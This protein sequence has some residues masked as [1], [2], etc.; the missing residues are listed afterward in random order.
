MIPPPNDAKAG[1]RAWGSIQIRSRYSRRIIAELGM[2]H[3]TSHQPSQQSYAAA[4][5]YLARVP[6]LPATAARLPCPPVC[7][8]V[9]HEVRWS[10]ETRVS[11]NSS[12]GG[13]QQHLPARLAWRACPALPCLGC[14]GTAARFASSPGQQQQSVVSSSSSSS[15]RTVWALPPQPLLAS[16]ITATLPR[17]CHLLNH[18][19][20][21]QLNLAKL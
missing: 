9:E 7:Y 13:Q 5:P 16:A 21:Q 14:R 2:D 10:C 12:N 8:L 1:S 17:A 15:S 3:R 18:N 6:R 4:Q 11:S 19:H 20:K